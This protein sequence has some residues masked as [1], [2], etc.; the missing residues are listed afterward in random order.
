MLSQ[1]ED[2]DAIWHWIRTNLDERSAEILWLRIQ[3]DLNLSE[4]AKV[5]TLSK[6]NVKVLL[7]RARKSLLKGAPTAQIHSKV[8]Q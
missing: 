2:V 4:I 6:T 1:Q 3:E 5:T 7:H 8:I